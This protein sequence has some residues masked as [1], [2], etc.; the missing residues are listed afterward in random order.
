MD[1]A[2]SCQVQKLHPPAALLWG[3]GT[4]V[5]QRRDRTMGW[6]QAELPADFS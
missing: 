6:H 1:K 4:A 3:V 5:P 2:R